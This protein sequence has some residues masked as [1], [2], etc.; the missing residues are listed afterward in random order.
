VLVR[1]NTN[2]SLDTSFG[3]GG[4]VT[5]PGTSDNDIKEGLVLLPDG[6]LVAAGAGSA[7]ALTLA[8]YNNNGKLDTS[9]GR[10]GKVT[11]VVGTT[12][13]FESALIL[14]PDGKL[15][16]A[17]GAGLPY[18][19]AGIN[20]FFVLRYDRDGS[21]DK[22]F[23]RHGK[24]TTVFRTGGN[25]VAETLLRQPNGKLVAAGS[26]AGGLGFEFALARYNPNGSL[27]T[28]FGR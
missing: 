10:N 15:L 26:S 4:K 13:N 6:K 5:A 7:S 28:S 16:A 3:H 27:D 22:S 9:F 17:G 19:G 24:V 20:D 2:G 1:Y 11:T 23:G 12:I 8:R 25:D 18:A 21:L 14:A